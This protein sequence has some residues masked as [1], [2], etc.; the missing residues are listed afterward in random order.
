M[1]AIRYHKLMSE[2]CR[3][4]EGKCQKCYLK[5]VCK[6]DPADITPLEIKHILK[7]LRDRKNWGFTIPHE[8]LSDLMHHISSHQSEST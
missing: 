2:H 1:N 7:Y 3:F 5:M 4:M 6:S 8:V